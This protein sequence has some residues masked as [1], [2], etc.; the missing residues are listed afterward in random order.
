MRLR[1]ETISS[2][3][4]YDGRVIKLRLDKVRLPDGQESSREIVEHRGAIAAVPLLSDNNIILIKQYRQAAG[5]ILLEI[6]AGTLEVGEKPED[7]AERELQEEIGYKPGKLKLLFS[8]YLAPGY[9]SEM[10]HTFL[11][12]DLVPSKAE[13][14]E[15]EFI[16]IVK[17]PVKETIGLIESGQI[18]D[19]KTICGILMV[20]KMLSES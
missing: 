20:E 2:E 10:L 11:A 3:R 9:S 6:P 14:D 4:I 8:S 13:N 16:E 18:K 15:D 12:E 19:A 17:V 1:E 7:C 5:E